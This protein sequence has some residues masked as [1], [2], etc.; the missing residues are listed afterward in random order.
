MISSFQG[1]FLHKETERHADAAKTVPH[2]CLVQVWLA[3]CRSKW[4]AHLMIGYNAAAMWRMIEWSNYCDTKEYD[5]SQSLATCLWMT[6]HSYERSTINMCQFM[7]SVT[8]VSYVYGD[9]NKFVHCSISG[10]HVVGHC[11][12]KQWWAVINYFL[13]NYVIKLLWS[14]WLQKFNYSKVIGMSGS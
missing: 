11:N 10:R 8:V 5:G 12:R 2:T 14:S 6:R 9:A 7:R 13:V 3:R 4:N 1:F